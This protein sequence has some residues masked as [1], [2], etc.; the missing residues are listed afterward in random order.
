M[1]VEHASLGDC[2]FCGTRVPT[3]N[4]LIEYEGGLYAECP[5]CT[6]PVNPC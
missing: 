2:P 6:V 5:D 1:S 3:A 4:T